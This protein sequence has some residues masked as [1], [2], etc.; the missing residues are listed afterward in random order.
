MIVTIDASAAAS[1][2][3]P[4]QASAAADAFLASSADR[5]FAAPGIFAWEV[6]NLIATRARRA[7]LEPGDL[8]D[9]LAGLGIEIASSPTSENVFGF[10]DAAMKHDLTLFDTA[11]LLHALGHGGGLAS[12]DAGL[13][14]A[15]MAAG[16]DVFDLRD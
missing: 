3:F 2:I 4:R 1:W 7:N 6:G 5:R 9:R 15:A 14:K 11:Y 16:V 12:R 10:I 13:L 8:I